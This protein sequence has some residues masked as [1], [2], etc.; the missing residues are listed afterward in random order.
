M[1]DETIK[2]LTDAVVAAQA[3]GLVSSLL[4]AD[5]YLHWILEKKDPAKS[6]RLAFDRI[7]AR[8]ET[9]EDLERGYEKRAVSEA[10]GMIEDF[11]R[12]VEKTIE[13]RGEPKSRGPR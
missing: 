13:A 10:R 12:K 8:L 7:T 5:L 2:K 3:M 11:F 6:L 9:G 4:T 1:P